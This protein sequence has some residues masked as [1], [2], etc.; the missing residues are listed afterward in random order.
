VEYVTGD[1]EKPELHGIDQFA[2]EY[3]QAFRGA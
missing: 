2:A 3:A 1:L